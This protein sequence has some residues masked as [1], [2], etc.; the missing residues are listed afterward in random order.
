YQTFAERCKITALCDIY[1]DNAEHMKRQYL[2]DCSIYSDYIELLQRV[3]IDLVSL[4]TLPYTHAE[5]TIHALQAGKHVIVEKPMASSLE[6]C[7]RMN[8][9]AEASGK[10]LSVISQNR[11]GD[12]VMKLKKVLDTGLAGRIVHAQINSFWW[13][14]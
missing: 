9:A 2:L 3:D 7:D 6:E 4:Y 11:F 10:I 8:E 1:P 12:A 5:I 14:G 13:R